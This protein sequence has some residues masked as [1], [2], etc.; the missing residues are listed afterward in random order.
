MGLQALNKAVE[1][2][3]DILFFDD[4]GLCEGCILFY[5]RVLVLNQIGYAGGVTKA[6]P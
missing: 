2:Y 5:G 4:C 3:F 6:R 1:K